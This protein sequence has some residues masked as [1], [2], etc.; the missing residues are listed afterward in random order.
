MHIFLGGGRGEMMDH[1]NRGVF[2]LMESKAAGAGET[3]EGV[4]QEVGD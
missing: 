1:L 2:P 4:D 3:F